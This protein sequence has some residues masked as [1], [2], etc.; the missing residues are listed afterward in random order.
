MLPDEVFT[1]IELWSIGAVRHSDHL[2]IAKSL[3]Y[4]LSPVNG[5]I[6]K[7]YENYA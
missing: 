2:A 6:I 1:R 4:Q 5:S 7:K 3:P